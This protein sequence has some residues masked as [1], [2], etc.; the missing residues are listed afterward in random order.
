M[1]PGSEATGESVAARY[2][3]V[4]TQGLQSLGFVCGGRGRWIECGARGVVVG[5]EG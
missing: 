4:E 1:E 5:G 3:A 2:A